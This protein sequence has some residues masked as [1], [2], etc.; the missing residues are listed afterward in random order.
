MAFLILPRMAIHP[1]FHARKHGMAQGP[2]QQALNAGR[3]ELPVVVPAVA[4]A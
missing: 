2:M 1:V 3:M 4:P